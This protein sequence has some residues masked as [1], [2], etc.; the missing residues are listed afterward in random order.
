MKKLLRLTMMC[1][2]LNSFAIKS[3]AQQKL[4]HYWHFNN[5]V[6]FTTVQVSPSIFPVIK[7]NYSSLDTNKAI[8]AYKPLAGTVGNLLT[9]WDA[10]SPGD[11]VNARMGQAAGV[12]FRPRNPSDSMQLMLYIPTSSYKNIT[13]KFET[14]K[15]SEIGRAHV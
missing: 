2:L 6:N 1:L 8:L 14:Q 9:F 4:I 10:V 11:T 5:L 3:N 13:I 7:A 15:S 12:G